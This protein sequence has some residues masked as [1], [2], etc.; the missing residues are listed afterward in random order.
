MSCQHKLFSRVL[1][2][3]PKAF[4]FNWESYQNI[5]SYFILNCCEAGGRVNLQI[6]G[7]KP[8]SYL[9][10]IRECSRNE[11]AH[12]LLIALPV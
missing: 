3:N 4:L 12:Y 9:T 2:F 1:A 8:Q 7:K 11:F 6:L 5:T 10:I